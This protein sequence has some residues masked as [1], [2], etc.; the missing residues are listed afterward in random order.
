[1][2]HRLARAWS[3]VGHLNGV[4]NGDELR[5][6]YN[7]CL[8]LLTTYHTELAQ[9][10]A[11]CAA[12]QRVVDREGARLQPAQ[13]KLLQNA[14]RDFRLAGVSLPA[15]RKQRFREVMERLATAQSKFDENVLDATNAYSKHVESESELAGL[16]PATV[17]RAREA[18]AADHR[19]GW[20][21]ALDAPNYQA[22]LT[23]ADN[24]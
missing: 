18:A 5:A 19:A 8:P 4:M 1:M 13:R 2:H 3:P 12:Y 16:P 21:L 11:L 20:L 22:V 17:Q 10:E 23:H 15:E 6:A 7:A 24:E 14:L 9:N